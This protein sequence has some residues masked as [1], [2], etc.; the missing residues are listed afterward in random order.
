MNADAAN[1]KAISRA[2]MACSAD[3][4]L[5]LQTRTKAPTL[6]PRM[7]NEARRSRILCFHNR[8]ATRIESASQICWLAIRFAY[9]IAKTCMSCEEI[10]DENMFDGMVANFACCICGGGRKASDPP[11]PP[12]GSPTTPKGEMSSAFQTV[13]SFSLAVGLATIHAYYMRVG[14]M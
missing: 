10:G 4:G 3:D 6:S 9:L 12:T 8:K 14:N 11:R 7:H 1:S 13:L 5:I 2:R